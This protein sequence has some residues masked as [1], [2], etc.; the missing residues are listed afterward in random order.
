MTPGA[1]AEPRY[2]QRT[3]GTSFP[4]RRVQGLIGS[5]NGGSVWTRGAQNQYTSFPFG[6]P[7]TKQGET[8]MREPAT[9]PSTHTHSHTHT[10][11]H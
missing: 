10:H 11:T 6:K 7:A 4:E 3:K 9:M 5:R 8:T 2:G 1:I